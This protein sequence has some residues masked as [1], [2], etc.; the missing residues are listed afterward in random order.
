MFGG[1][2]FY[3]DELFVA[4][5]AVL[6]DGAPLTGKAAR[7]A[8]GIKGVQVVSEIR[9]GEAK[10]GT[11][12]VVVNGVDRNLSKVVHTTWSSGSGDVAAHL[13]VTTAVAASALE[14]LQ[15]VLDGLGFPVRVMEPA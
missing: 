3:V 14:Q 8:A 11:K 6:G 9:S 5:Y 4:D 7:T 15:R 1:R 2:G 12:K 10:L 13:G